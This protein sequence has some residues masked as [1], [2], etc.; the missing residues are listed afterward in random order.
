MSLK[1][2]RVIKE[3]LA[4]KK[5]LIYIGMVILGVIILFSVIYGLRLFSNAT[6][7]L[8]VQQAEE[9]VRCAT[10]I[11]GDGAAIDCWKVNP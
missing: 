7:P 1:G 4:M 5:N 10:L 11:T 9:N 8:I 6:T 3:G 2:F